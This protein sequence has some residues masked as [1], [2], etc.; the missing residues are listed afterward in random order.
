MGK[1]RLLSFLSFFCGQFL[2]FNDDN[3]ERYV[4]NS[5]YSISL[6]FSFFFFSDARVMFLW[7]SILGIDEHI[8][9][10]KRNGQEKEMKR[11]QKT[12]QETKTNNLYVI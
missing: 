5:K 4:K 3:D 10:K 7:Y 9:A 8:G 1:K 11:K 6:L 12:Q 2:L